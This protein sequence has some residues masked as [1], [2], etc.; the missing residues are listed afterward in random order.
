MA[1]NGPAY[2]FTLEDCLQYAM[3]NSYTHQS[4]S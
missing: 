2:Y 4:P 1:Q 3:D